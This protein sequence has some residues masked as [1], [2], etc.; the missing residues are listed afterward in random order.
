[1]SDIQH[2]PSSLPLNQAFKP[3]LRGIRMKAMKCPYCGSRMKKNGKTKAGRQRWRCK[4]CGASS[5]KRYDSTSHDLK[6]FLDWLLSKRVQL[7]MP[8]CGRTFRRHAEKFW[9]IWSMPPVIDEILRVIHVDGI[10]LGR[11]AVILSLAQKSMF[12]LGTLLVL[13]A[14]YPIALFSPRSL[15]LRWC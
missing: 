6:V 11:D 7:D 12:S 8:G 13:R 3:D 9:R 4:A 5:I 14:L 15:H 2:N 1:M 10:W